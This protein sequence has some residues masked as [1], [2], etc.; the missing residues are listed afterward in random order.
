VTFGERD[1]WLLQTGEARELSSLQTY[2]PR[3]DFVV[4]YTEKIKFRELQIG[5]KKC[6]ALTLA[7]CRLRCDPWIDTKRGGAVNKS[8]WGIEH[9]SCTG[10]V[11]VVDL[12]NFKKQGVLVLLY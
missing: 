3:L 4:A 8:G 5:W 10:S 6:A 9:W 11:V 1:S 2:W 12:C 7:V